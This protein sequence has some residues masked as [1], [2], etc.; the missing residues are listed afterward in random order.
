MPPVRYLVLTLQSV[1]M[2]DRSTAVLLTTTA[3]PVTCRHPAF[4]SPAGDGRG[5]ESGGSSRKMHINTLVQLLLDWIA[6][7]S[8]SGTTL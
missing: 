8:C 5:A 7:C 6:F 3:P 1:T 4:S 2:L